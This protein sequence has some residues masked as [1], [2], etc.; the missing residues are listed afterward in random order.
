MENFIGKTCP[1]CKVEFKECDAVKICPVCGIPHHETCWNENNGCATY[2][3]SEQNKVTSAPVAPA[4]PVCT[5]CGTTLSAD[6]MFCPKCGTAKAVP[7]PSF[8]GKCGAEL[9]NGQEFCA[10]CGQKVGLTIDQN[11]NNA[12]NQFNS[13]IQSTTDDKKKK[14]KKKP[15][16]IVAVILVIVIAL[17]AL[18]GGGSKSDFNTMYSSIAGESWCEIATDGTWMKLDTNPYDLD[19]YNNTTAWSKIKTVLNDLGFPSSVS[20]EMAETRALDGKQTASTD[21]YEVSW[22]YHPDSGLETMFKVK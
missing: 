15:L 4:A 6:Q 8:C 22:T 13:T 12:I 2:G 18:S 16:I 17:I 20:E 19:D 14:D 10:K 7:Q 3:C 1:F 11:V 9:Q 5:N 21:E